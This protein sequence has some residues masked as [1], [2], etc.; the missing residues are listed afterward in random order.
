MLINCAAIV[1]GKSFLDLSSAEIE[2]TLRVNVLGAMNVSKSILPGMLA[3]KKPCHIIN[4]ASVL[5]KIGVKKMT[6]YCASKFAI[7][8]FYESLRQELAGR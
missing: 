4:I 3:S 2:R 1:N 5:G 7:V 8:G 6:D